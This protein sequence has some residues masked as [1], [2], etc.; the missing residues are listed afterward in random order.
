MLPRLKKF[1]NTTLLFIRAFEIACLVVRRKD[2][3]NPQQK[4][5]EE[6]VVMVMGVSKTVISNISRE[7]TPVRKRK[8]KEEVDYEAESIP[9]ETCEV[10]FE[11]LELLGDVI[12]GD[13]E[14]T[15]EAKDILLSLEGSEL[16]NQMRSRIASLLDQIDTPGYSGDLKTPLAD[17]SAF[18]T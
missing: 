2:K 4:R 17:L 9:L 8:E 10:S 7:P 6:P 11:T 5:K 3:I 15:D 16:G 14:V 18:L 1:I 12:S 13:S